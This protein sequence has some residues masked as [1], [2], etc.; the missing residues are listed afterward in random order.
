MKT[1]ICTLALLI[2]ST[3]AAQQTPID[4]ITAAVDKAAAEDKFSGVVLVAKDGMPLLSRAWGMADPAKGIANRAD[5]K[6]NL[7]SINKIFTHVAIGQLAAAGKLSIS[8]TI[9]KHLPDLPVPSTDKITIEQLLQHRSGLGD[10]FGPKFIDSHASIRKLSDY[11]PLFAGAPLQFEPGADQKYSNAGFVILGLIIEKVSG[12]NYYDYIRDHITKPAGMTDTASYA[13]DENVPNRASGLTKRGP[14]GP[15]PERQNNINT[16]PARGSSAGGGYSTAA[17]LLRFSQ[18]LLADKLLPKRWTD[19]IFS[20]KLDG[21]GQRNIGVAGGSPGVNAVLEIEPPYTVIVMSNFDPPAAME[22]G[23]EVRKILG[24]GGGERRQRRGPEGPGEVIIHGKVQ[25]PMDLTRHV[26]V[27]E[28]KVNGKGP[29][30][31]QV[32]TGFGGMIQVT[33]AVAKTL[34]LPV[35]GESIG[36][37]PSGKNQ[38]TMRVYSAESVDV[39]DAHFGQVEAVEGGPHFEGI[40]GVIGLQLF[41]S[42]IVTFDYPNSRFNVDG[43]ALPA[44]DGAK[45][46]T[47]RVDHG[48]PNIDIDVA[49]QKVKTDIDS[50]SPAL[51]SMPLSLAKSLPLASEPQVVGHGRTVGNEFDIYSAPMKGEVR[52]GAITLTDPRVDFVDLFPV[53]N[54][55][56]RFLKDYVVTFDPANHRV[57]F[58]K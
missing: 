34:A 39:G 42:L 58:V 6:F 22:I 15:L 38:R 20:G 36:G 9:A 33:P 17:D 21:A 7:G 40:D 11:V 29:F 57:R 2:A 45:I 4:Q 3:L 46:L 30:R 25:L 19:W 24:I 28:A 43:G 35:I 48:V 49:G 1:L 27:I 44:A 53:A 13:V 26:P 14:D 23:A 55:G 51:L 32:D 54:L 18:A 31:F 47:Y 5:T 8:D 10:I 50:G 41:N 12:Q 37:D 56:F 52:V 16:L